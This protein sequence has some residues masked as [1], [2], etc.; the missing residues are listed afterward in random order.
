M[1][2]LRYNDLPKGGFAGLRERQLVIDR[3]MNRGQIHP[4]AADGIGNFVYM[5]DAN[6]MP[7]GQ[8]GM[9]PHREVDVISVMVDGRI[10]HAGSLKHGQQ[11]SAGAVQVQRAGGE[12][13]SHNEI[14]PD[15]TENNMIQLWVL[16]EVQGEKADYKV[17]EPKN[18]QRLR[19]YG[20]DEN[21]Q[22]TFASHTL[23]DIVQ[24]LTGELL[25]H[26]GDVM[27]YVVKGAAIINGE[28]IQSRTLV[29]D[30]GLN[31]KATADSKIILVYTQ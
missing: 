19:I 21:Q 18:G 16:P 30:N 29:R 5:A 8:T 28:A 1:K 6:F 31:I 12:G 25:E 27:A 15:N 9:H 24:P 3:K 14:N 22:D 13:F 7:K 23:I 11:L 4:T 10:N 2:I 26:K 20:G 17:Y